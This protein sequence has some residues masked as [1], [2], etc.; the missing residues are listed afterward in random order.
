MILDPLGAQFEYKDTKFEITSVGEDSIDNL[1]TGKINEK[2]LE[3]SNLN[4]GKKSRSSNSLSGS[5][6]Y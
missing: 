5:I 3:I 4:I 6:K 1:P 2:G